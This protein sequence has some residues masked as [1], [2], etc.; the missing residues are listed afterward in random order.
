MNAGTAFGQLSGCFV[1]PVP[2]SME[3][4]FDSLKQMAIVQKTGGGTGFS[5]SGL[6][7]RGTLIRSTG[8]RSSGP[9][10]FMRIFDCATEQVEQ[11]GRRRG[12]NMGVLRVDH[13]DI[14][15]FIDAKREEGALRNFNISVA[16]SDHFME[17]VENGRSY[18]LSESSTG[19]KVGEK[20]AGEVFGKIAEAAWATGDPG[21][22]SRTQSTWRTPSSTSAP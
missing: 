21:L 19:R 6:R 3:G 9:V 18:A 22:S 5:F 15:E 13:P 14:E 2:D 17:A 16:V 7:Q 8:G 11:G 4:I 20:S 12:A 1:L 10:S